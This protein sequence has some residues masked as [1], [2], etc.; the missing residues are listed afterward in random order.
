[1]TA[2]K[3]ISETSADIYLIAM[4]LSDDQVECLMALAEPQHIQIR[5]MNSDLLTRFDRRPFNKTQSRVGGG[6]LYGSRIVPQ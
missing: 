2:R 3:W 5:V 4:G 1:M 6:G